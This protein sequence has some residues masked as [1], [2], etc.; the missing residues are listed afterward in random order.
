MPLETA[1][2]DEMTDA[3]YSE[4]EMESETETEVET[5]TPESIDEMEA[6]NPTALI[7][8]SAL[9]K[10]P[11]EGDTITLKVV[12]IHDGEAE[13]ELSTGETKPMKREMMAPD[14]EL[15]EMAKGY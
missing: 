3:F 9:G 10:N 13:V 1:E 2:T 8:T 11:K 6:E 4:P 7:P 15:D 5:E 12:A 14:D